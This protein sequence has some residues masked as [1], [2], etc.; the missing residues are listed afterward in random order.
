MSRGGRSLAC[1][2]VFLRDSRTEACSFCH[3]TA[4]GNLEE[5]SAIETRLQLTHFIC[6]VL[7]VNVIHQNSTGTDISLTATIMLADYNMSKLKY[8]RDNVLIVLVSQ[9]SVLVII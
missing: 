7:Y 1:L 6:V 3:F 5:L 8:P 2:R 4:S 9:H